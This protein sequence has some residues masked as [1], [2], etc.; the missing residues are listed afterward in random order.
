VLI[1]QNA[2]LAFGTQVICSNVNWVIPPGSRIALV[3]DNGAGK[4]TLLKV[5]T[6]EVELDS[7]MLVRPDRSLKIGYLPQ[8]PLNLGPESILS[9]LKNEC[10]LTS[11]EKT[12]QA[13]AEI[14]AQGGGEGPAAAA[15]Q[16]QYD[17]AQAA[18]KAGDGYSFAARAWEILAGLGFKE[19]DRNKNCQDFS[20]GWKMRIYLAQLL[21][22]RPDIL[23]LDE[24][25]NHLDTPSLEWLEK[26]LADYRGTLIT[27]THDRYFLDRVTTQ[28]AELAEGKIAVFPGPYTRYLAE[29]AKKDEL[30]QKEQEL[31][32]EQIA[33]HEAFIN[34]FRYQATKARQVQ[35][36]LKLLA[37]LPPPQD[38]PAAERVMQMRFPEP[39]KADREVIKAEAAGKIYEGKTVFNNIDLTIFRGEKVALVGLNGSGKSTLTRLLARTEEPSAGKIL[40][41]RNV[42]LALFSQESAENLHYLNTVWEEILAV[43]TTCDDQQ[44]RNLLGAFLFRGEEVSKPVSVLSGGEKTRLTLLKILLSNTNVLILDEPTNHLD[45]KTREV[46]E[47]AMLEYRGTLLVVSHDRHFLD[48]VASRTLE[49]GN[50]KISDYPGNYSYY[51]EKKAEANLTDPAR[52]EKSPPATVGSAKS[53]ARK[54]AV[55]ERSHLYLRRSGLKKELTQVEAKIFSLEELKAHQEACLCDPVVLRNQVQTKELYRKLAEI[56][57]ELRVLYLL[58]ESLGEKL[59][60]LAKTPAGD[61]QLKPPS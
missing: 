18:L 48:R 2:S 4:T 43:D 21:L 5:I 37:K 46:F 26:Y 50:G 30:L 34:R 7:G 59:S 9:F 25:T 40:W 47:K 24:P 3:G 27:V 20:G 39:A 33:R 38:L 22:S 10:G 32:R 57:E 51:M 6:G 49:L 42:R 45:R 1:F 41:G 55:Q 44:K 29:K 11:L 19:E 23:L 60:L 35:S 56:T 52:K 12:L 58:W 54:L 61:D 17:Q 13:C 14:I 53:M 16:E 31:F 15:A 8:E 36:R 28:I